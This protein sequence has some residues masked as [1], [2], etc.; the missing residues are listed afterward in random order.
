MQ[1]IKAFLSQ[2]YYI[3]STILVAVAGQADN[4]FLQFVLNFNS[5]HNTVAVISGYRQQM[6]QI[7]FWITFM[8][9]Q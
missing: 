8:N 7:S 3:F 2:I 4:I 6:Q 5:P 1:R 9:G